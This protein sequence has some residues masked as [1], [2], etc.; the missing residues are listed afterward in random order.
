MVLRRIYADGGVFR[1]PDGAGHSGSTR[2]K[3]G[4]SFA[5]RT[6][7]ARRKPNCPT[8]GSENVAWK[9]PLPGRG[10]SSPVVFADR[11]YLTAYTGYGLTNEAPGNAGDLV[12]HLFCIDAEDGSVVWQKAVPAQSDKNEFNNWGVGVHGYASSTAAVDKT[13]IYV[14]FGATGVLAFDL[15]GE[16]RWRAELG[17]GHARFRS[18][19]LAGAVQ[20]H[21]DHQRQR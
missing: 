10:S 18:R 20:E 8:V 3:S 14:F 21:G 4:L 11:I 13:G 19:Q 5:V 2:A 17:L 12:R 16:E 15:E 7:A 9:T 6:T 1:P